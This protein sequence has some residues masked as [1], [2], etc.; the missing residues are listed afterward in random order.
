M[1]KAVVTSKHIWPDKIKKKKNEEK[2]KKILRYIQK[3]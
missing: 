1:V 2:E 3:E